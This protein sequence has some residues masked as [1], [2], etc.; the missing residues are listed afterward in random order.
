M[1][2]NGDGGVNITDAV[3]ML[4]QLFGGGPVHVLGRTCR[5]IDGSTC[6][7]TCEILQ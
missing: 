7:D 4:N 1:D 3:G 6:D 2:H 5:P